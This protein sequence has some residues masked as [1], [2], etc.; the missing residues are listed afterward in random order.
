MSW[1]PNSTAR[2]ALVICS[3]VDSRRVPSAA[4]TFSKIA[5]NASTSTYA[6]PGTPC[7]ALTTSASRAVWPSARWW[8]PKR[9]SSVVRSAVATGSQ[10]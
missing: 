2:T 4:V 3:W 6:T 9:C 7:M 8:K 5:P 1:S 10:L